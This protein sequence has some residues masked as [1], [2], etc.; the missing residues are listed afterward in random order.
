MQTEISQ[1]ETVK[2]PDY[3]AFEN[4]LISVLF[5]RTRAPQIH[6]F[7]LPSLSRPYHSVARIEILPQMCYYTHCTEHRS[8]GKQPTVLH[9]GKQLS[10]VINNVFRLNF[11]DTLCSC[12]SYMHMRAR[13]DVKEQDLSKSEAVN[14]V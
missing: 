9:P 2:E 5:F 7:A 13:K 14:Y 6:S 3:P 1:A 11:P 8:G 12:R 4:D 10:H